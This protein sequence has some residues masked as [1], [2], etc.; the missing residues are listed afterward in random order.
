MSSR[1]Q[2]KFLSVLPSQLKQEIPLLETEFHQTAA[3][4]GNFASQ[5]EYK[6]LIEYFIDKLPGEDILILKASL[7]LKWV[8]SQNMKTDRLKQDIVERYGVRGKNISNLCSAGY[9]ETVIKVLYEEMKRD[10]GFTMEKFLRVYEEIIIHYPFAVFIHRHMN[11]KAVETLIKKKV[12]DM[13]KYGIFTLNIHGIGKSN[14]KRIKKAIR[15]LKGIVASA[16]RVGE[17]IIVVKVKRNPP[18]L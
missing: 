7:Y 5:P 14:V 4:F 2:K 17:N 13:E 18:M 11:A 3:K 9:F 8:L 16:D 15:E 10:P 6:D 1:Q 12:E